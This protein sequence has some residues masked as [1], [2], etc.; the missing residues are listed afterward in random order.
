M[1]SAS[2]LRFDLID[3]VGYGYHRVWQERT[4]LFRLA[5]VPFVIKFFMAL[6]VYAMGLEDDVLRR[7]LIMLPGALVEGWVLAQFLRTLMLEERWPMPIPAPGDELAIGKLILRARGIISSTLVY[8]LIALFANVI[9]WGASLLDGSMQEAVQQQ[10]ATGTPAG[11]DSNP[12]FFIPALMLMA[13]MI[14]AFPLLWIYIPYVVLVPVREYFPRV[15]GFLNSLKMFGIFLICMVPFN[16][17]AALVTYAF[18]TPF[19]ASV[20]DAPIMIRFILIFIS[21]A[22]DMLTSIIV[23]TGIVYALRDILPRHPAAL[24]DVR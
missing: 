11:H 13:G 7:G 23:T 3:S 18:V 10:A 20:D 6:T 4:Y 22:A 5:L 16:V 17:A 8:V 2:P 19:G 12:I 1:A 15:R 24:A 9:G 21:V 14:L